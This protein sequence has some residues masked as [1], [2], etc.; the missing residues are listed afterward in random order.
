M[1]RAALKAVV[2]AVACGVVVSNAAAAPDADLKAE[3]EAFIHRTEAAFDGRLHWEGVDTFEVAPGGDAATLVNLRFS[4]RKDG[5]DLKPAVSVSFDRMEIRRKAAGGDGKL[6]EFAVTLPATST[7]TT[8][9]GTEI[10]LSLTDAHLTALVENPGERQRAATLTL[11]GGRIEDKGGKGHLGF[12]PLTGNWKILRAENGSWTAPVDI[13]LKQ[14]D[15][16]SAEA[17]LAATADRIVYAATAAGPNLAKFDAWRDRANELK[18]QA[19]GNPDKKIEAWASLLPDLLTIFSNSRGELMVEK[20]IAKRP[21]GDTPL[22]TLAKAK[23]GGGFTGLDGEKAGFRMVIGHDGLV[24]D[25]SLMPENQVPRRAIVDFGLEDIATGALRSLAEAASLAGPG[26]TDADK[27]KA[28]QQFI[29]V[30]VSLNPVL[31]IYDASADFKHVSLDASGEAKRAPPA[32]IGYAASGDVRVRGFD[33]LP[34]IV[35]GWL[36]RAQLPLLKLIGAA[37][38]AADSA[39]V[40]KFH[41][42]SAMGKPLTVNDSN[43]AAWLDSSV[44][45]SP[46]LRTLHLT[47]PPMNGDDVRAVQKKLPAPR[48]G[49]FTD[50]VYDG[51]TAL[52]VARFQKQAGLNVDGVVDAATRDKLG[53]KPPPASSPPASATPRPGKSAAPKN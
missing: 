34:E 26:A 18:E 14:L 49:T 45:S 36:A 4:F 48:D 20:V 13:E 25:P 23:L 2:V 50:G 29:A 16:L 35:T 19:Q 11:G 1:L 39:P 38:T 12:G 43:L 51:P 7:M 37:E 24:I 15:F 31:R 9:D 32:P 52:A 21:D 10:G 33:A 53:I 6:T 41:I 27:Q 44:S 30:G 5:G 8:D 47:D 42:A 17:P 22:V 28:M 3:I 40:V 46:G